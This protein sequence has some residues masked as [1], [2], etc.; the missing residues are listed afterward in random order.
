MCVCVC[1]RPAPAAVPSGPEPL[2]PRRQLHQEQAR[3]V[4]QTRHQRDALVA[5]PAHRGECGDGCGGQ[6]HLCLSVCLHPAICSFGSQCRE[7]C[8]PQRLR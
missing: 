7:M 3:R 6:N 2:Q 5:L 4:A 1:V 8:V